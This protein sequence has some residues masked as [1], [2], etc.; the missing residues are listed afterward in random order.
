[1]YRWRGRKGGGG[2]ERGVGAMSAVR[3]GGASGRTEAAIERYSFL[4][5]GGKE[6]MWAVRAVGM[7]ACG[8]WR[9]SV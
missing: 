3:A 4:F 8:W 6:D 2:G 5:L 1:M 9:R 7:E